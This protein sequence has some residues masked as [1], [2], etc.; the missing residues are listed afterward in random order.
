MLVKQKDKAASTYNIYIDV[1]VIKEYSI[2][3]NF[4]SVIQK[5]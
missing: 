4:N 3:L 2:I 5:A 1:L